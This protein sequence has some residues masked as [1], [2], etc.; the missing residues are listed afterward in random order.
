[1]SDDDKYMENFTQIYIEEFS[2]EIEKEV[3][4]VIDD[5]VQLYREIEEINFESAK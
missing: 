5:N 1:M 3:L 2:R 4:K